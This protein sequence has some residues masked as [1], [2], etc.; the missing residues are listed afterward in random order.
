MRNGT[1]TVRLALLLAIPLLLVSSGF[2]DA[3]PLDSPRDLYRALNALRVDPARV[4]SVRDL[5]LRR[6]A[7]SIT[8]NEGNLGFF[9]SL[10]GRVS[11]AV[12]T[13]QGRA[14]ATPQEAA[15]RRS[16]AQFLGV[17]L[18]DQPFTRAYLRFTDGTAAELERQL[19]RAGAQP[20]T[21]Q[22]FADRWSLTVA[23]L[24]P[25]QSLRVM[26]DWLAADPLPYFYADLAGETIGPFDVLVDDRRPEQVLIGQPRQVEGSNFYDVWASFSRSDAPAATETFV[27]LGYTIETHIAP[28]R[29]LEGLTTVRLRAM[30]G[31]ERMIL[32]DMS[33]YLEAQKATDGAGRPLDFFQNAGINR[34]E[35]ARRGNDQLVVVLPMAVSAGDEV[36]L[37]I[38]YRGGVISNAGNGVFFVGQRAGWYPHVG[39]PDRFVPFD[40]TFSWPKDLTLVATGTKLEEHQEGDNTV[41]HYRS[42]TPAALAGFNLGDYRR[43]VASAV[44]PRVELLANKQLESAILRILQRRNLELD[45][46]VVEGVR[47]G[48][49][50]LPAVASASPQPMPNPAAV[51]KQ[52]GTNIVSSIHYF[53][54]LNGPFPFDS[55]EVSQIPGTFGQGWPG[56]LYLSTFVFLPE[57]TQERIGL[58]ASLREGFSEIVP[59]HEVAHQWWGNEVGI[60]SYRD[61]WLFEAMANY[62]ALLYADSKKPSDHLLDHWLV[63][64]RT[65]L[66]TKRPD[67]EE[68]PEQAGPLTLG[69]RLSSSK[70]PG[71]YDAVVYGK[72]TWV[73]HMLRMML[74]DPAAKDPDA[75]FTE[76]LH[77]LLEQH[78]YQALST[79]D[80]ERAV[81]QWM[82]PEMDL[83]GSHSMDWFFDEWVRGTGV[84]S[85]SVNYELRS[86]GK[87]FVV[88]GTLRQ[89]DVP[90]EFT[91][92]VPLYAQPAHGSPVLL[93]TVATTGPET[94]FEFVSTV[95]PRHVLIDPHMTL[96]CRTE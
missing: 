94:K 75:R 60:A 88:R 34:N 61:A 46:S 50:R 41:A 45:S 54:K 96:L 23:N 85:Y 68:A 3:P 30:R 91:A 19:Q 32:L 78:R 81:E 25:D 4:Y 35:I 28:D 64:L 15:E 44:N 55:L 70:T 26:M 92:A 79:A 56:L 51:L 74:R 82:T 69:Y 49:L 17:P 42:A 16:L 76:L 20:R 14:I 9:A 11:G 73:M 89:S 5:S 58:G 66:L 65:A 77:R 40:L 12:F 29:S 13:G 37:K 2:A 39:G 59:Y 27:P 36:E 24:D 48:R 72:G 43:E 67:Q 38:S 10:D 86:Q 18:L 71:A 21:D 95:R 57:E 22:E 87:K 6:D 84:P 53:E 80:F 62:Q 31:G 63:R 93:G 47:R 90:D 33:R 1:R 83:E 7:V 52:L 8:F